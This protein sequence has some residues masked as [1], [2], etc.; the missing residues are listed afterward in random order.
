MRAHNFRLMD[1]IH[2]LLAEAAATGN[3]VVLFKKFM[4]RNQRKAR[5]MRMHEELLNLLRK[6]EV[7]VD[8]I[9]LYSSYV[10]VPVNNFFLRETMMRMYCPLSM[11][12]SNST[13]SIVVSMLQYKALCTPCLNY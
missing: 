12:H 6:I 3:I 13:I 2:V 11:P 9:S 1:M 5:M 8:K 10:N 7:R 4:T